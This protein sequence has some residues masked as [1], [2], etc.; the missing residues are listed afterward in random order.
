[1]KDITG[2]KFGK[3]TRHIYVDHDHETGEIRGLLCHG[4]NS[5]LGFSKEN[6]QTLENT[7]KYLKEHQDAPTD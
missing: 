4:C 5:V 6:I 3:L 1:M 2:Q 7:I